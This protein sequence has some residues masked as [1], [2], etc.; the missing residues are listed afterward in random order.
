[1]SKTEV[2]V[3]PPEFQ[4]FFETMST[5]MLRHQSERGDSWKEPMV[6]GYLDTDDYLVGILKVVAT[7]YFKTKD[8]GELVDMANI[9]GML[10]CR[11]NKPFVKV[12][13]VT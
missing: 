13:E 1:M 11:K 10:W 4:E 9:C 5:E 2:M 8:V 3:F 6:H 12:E 7:K